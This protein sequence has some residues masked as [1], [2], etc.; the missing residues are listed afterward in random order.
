MD[1]SSEDDTEVDNKHRWSMAVGT[2][3]T[4][5]FCQHKTIKEFKNNDI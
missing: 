3:G 1:M 4:P 2:G 5:I